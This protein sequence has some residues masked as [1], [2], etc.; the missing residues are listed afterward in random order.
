M[1]VQHYNKKTPEKLPDWLLDATLDI[2]KVDDTQHPQQQQYQKELEWFTST[3]LCKPKKTWSTSLNAKQVYYYSNKK[4]E[5]VIQ[6]NMKQCID[7]HHS[8]TNNIRFVYNSEDSDS[9]TSHLFYFC[10]LLLFFNKQNSMIDISNSET[11]NFYCS[12]ACF[13]ILLLYDTYI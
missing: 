1:E 11:Q 3:M 9:C 7:H 2:C 6:N 10:L 5:Q 12:C 13:A 4:K 8:I